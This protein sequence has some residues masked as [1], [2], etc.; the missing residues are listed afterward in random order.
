MRSHLG[1]PPREPRWSAGSRAGPQENPGMGAPSLRP[2]TTDPKQWTRR[3]ARRSARLQGSPAT[4][5]VASQ[6][7]EATKK[8][9]EEKRA[10]AEALHKERARRRKGAGA[11][12]SPEAA[13]RAKR[14]P[15]QQRR[16]QRTRKATQAVFP[17]PPEATEP[18]P[19]STL[20]RGNI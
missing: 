14:A 2:E 3:C 1:L 7:K 9:K 10:Q 5:A 6:R 16:Q 11:P 8:E 12:P 13:Q 18:L 4:E 17:K 19:A 15:S 20:G